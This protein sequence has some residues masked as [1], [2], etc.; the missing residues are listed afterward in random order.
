MSDEA[1]LAKRIA[2]GTGTAASLLVAGAGV[3]GAQA[4][5]ARRAAGVRQ[6]VPPYADGRYGGTRG[7]SL[8]LAVLGD[9]L[10][11][12]LGAEFP[13]ETPGA[14][15]AERLAHEARQPVV[16]STTAV[17]GARSDHL[18]LQVERALIIRPTIAVILIGANDITHFRPLR[19]QV[20]LLRH[21]ILALREAGV[22]VVLGTCPDLGSAM[23]IPP[24]SRQVARRQSRRLASMQT[25]AALQADAITVSL[26]D[27]LG[28][29]FSARP[30]ELFAADRF[31]PNAAGYAAVAEVLTPAVLSAAGFGLAGL[32]ERYE[33]A[34]TERIMTAIDHAVAAPGTVL[35]PVDHP[36]EGE[37]RTLASM[38]LRRRGGPGDATDVGRAASRAD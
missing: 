18:P 37:R 3:L 24:P 16:L 35:A 17:V 38:L 2:A 34:R 33:L 8:R 13:H 27:T 28:P 32:P 14:I 26:G 9:S 22:Q 7:V 23:L 25:G 10:A 5:A 31:H 4:M 21:N 12:G 15:L 36:P 6:T 19:R 29:E 11:A 20:R 1:R 30:S